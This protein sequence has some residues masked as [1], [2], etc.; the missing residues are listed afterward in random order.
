[1]TDDIE[2]I[3]TVMSISGLSK[4][5][6]SKESACSAGDTGSVLGREDA[7]EEGMATHCSTLAWRIPWTEEPG[8]LQSKGSQR[9]RHDRGDWAHTHRLFATGMSFRWSVCS[10][11]LSVH[12]LIT[13][14]TWN[15]HPHFFLSSSPPM[16]AA[17]TLHFPRYNHRF[18]LGMPPSAKMGLVNFT[19]CGV[20]YASILS[21]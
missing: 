21:F 2:H 19:L 20:Y 3:S 8:G 7:L 14:W 1:M 6:G 18:F 4:W 17:L 9:V 5:F 13:L 16:R 10:N 12:F 15:S 11:L